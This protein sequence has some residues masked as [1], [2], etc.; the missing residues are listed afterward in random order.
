MNVK[1]SIL[2]IVNEAHFI[3]NTR[4]VYTGDFCCDFSCD[5]LLLEDVKE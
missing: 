4:P 3:I 2:F 1:T 5:F